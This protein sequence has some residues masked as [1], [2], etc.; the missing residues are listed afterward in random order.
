MKDDDEE[1]IGT[2]L[3]VQHHAPAKAGSTVTFTATIVQLQGHSIICRYEARVD[4]VIIATGEQGQKILKKEK[5]RK[6][7]GL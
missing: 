6:L 4:N 1:G 2:M 5:L 7:F 3:T